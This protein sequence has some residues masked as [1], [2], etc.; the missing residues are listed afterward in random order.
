MRDEFRATALDQIAG[1]G[2]DVLQQL[3]DVAK[4]GFSINEFGDGLTQSGIGLD[5]AGGA[6]RACRGYMLY[7]TWGHVTILSLHDRKSKDDLFSNLLP[8]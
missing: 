6:R 3:E 1:F 7:R 2:H 5:L 4:A 8:V